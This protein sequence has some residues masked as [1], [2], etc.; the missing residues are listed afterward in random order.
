MC[1]LCKYQL[2]LPPSSGHTAKPIYNTSASYSRALG[3]SAHTI[4]E[5]GSWLLPQTNAPTTTITSYT[6]NKS[7]NLEKKKLLKCP[8]S[9][10]KGSLVIAVTWTRWKF[11]LVLSPLNMWVTLPKSRTLGILYAVVQQRG[12]GGAWFLKWC[13]KESCYFSAQKKKS[14]RSEGFCAYRQ[15]DGSFWRGDTAANWRNLRRH[16]NNPLRWWWRG[17]IASSSFGG[18]NHSKW[19]SKSDRHVSAAGQQIFGLSTW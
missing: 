3:W 16:S 18:A 17:Q 4:F 13:E 7:D 10:P 12:P 9:R 19:T 6:V 15:R 5:S 1:G 2:L 11:D 8:K 14:D